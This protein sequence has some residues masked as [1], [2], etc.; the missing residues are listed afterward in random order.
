M[1]AARARTTLAT[2]RLRAGQLDAVPPA[3]APVLALP[4]AQ[5]IDS[6]AAGLTQLRS[7]LARPRY[8]GAA[9]AGELT[10]QIR[11]FLRETAVGRR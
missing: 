11:L 2:T 9:G 4:R 8:R 10:E 1:R 6:I 5:R 3:I 7:E